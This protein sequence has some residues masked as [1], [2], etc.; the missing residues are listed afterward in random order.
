MNSFVLYA[1]VVM[2]MLV[3]FVCTTLCLAW[4]IPSWRHRLGKIA[5]VPQVQDTVAVVGWHGRAGNV[6]IAS[7]IGACAVIAWYGSYS[8]LAALL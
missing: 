1:A 8:V 6:L 2:M 3:A 5:I 4:I 7:G